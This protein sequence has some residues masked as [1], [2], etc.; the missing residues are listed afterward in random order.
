MTA[1][2]ILKAIRSLPTDERRALAKHLD[3][4]L[5]RTADADEPAELAA[6]F[7]ALRNDPLQRPPQGTLEDRD[8]LR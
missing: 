1:E 3:L 5:S 8:E 4:E 6:L 2:E 7:G